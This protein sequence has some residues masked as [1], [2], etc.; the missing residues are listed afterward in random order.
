M[1]AGT[2]IFHSE[3]NEHP[4]EPVRFM[5]IWISP[6][7][8]EVKPNYGSRAYHDDARKNKWL[9][10]VSSKAEAA[11]NPQLIG[12]YQDANVFVTEMDPGQKLHFPVKENR[13]AYMTCVEG[14]TILN[15]G[16]ETLEERDSLKIRGHL[17]LE[18]QAP[19][20]TK[21]HVLVIEMPL[22]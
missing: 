2:G 9:H 18:L 3:M 10:L 21:S 13:Q 4:C 19:E 5:Q 22:D 1:S 12:F 8:K 11:K 20:D 16:L 6:N 17:D 15:R 7:V 14:K